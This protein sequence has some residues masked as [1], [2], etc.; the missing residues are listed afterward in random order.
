MRN[1]DFKKLMLVSSVSVLVSFGLAACDKDKD[2][3][4]SK[5]ASETTAPITSSEADKSMIDDAKDEAMKAAEGA[6]GAAEEEAKKAMD[7][8]T[9]DVKEDAEKAAED[10]MDAAKK[11]A[12]EAKPKIPD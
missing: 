1:V 11:K 12:E 3:K 6:M 7:D 8:A 10:L 2:D 9:K 5:A 4:T